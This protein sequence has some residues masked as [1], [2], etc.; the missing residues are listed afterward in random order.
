MTIRHTQSPLSDEG[1]RGESL[2]AGVAGKGVV[3]E[4]GLTALGGG[5]P[6]GLGMRTA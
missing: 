4:D 1:G 5:Q 6:D 2:T 3:I